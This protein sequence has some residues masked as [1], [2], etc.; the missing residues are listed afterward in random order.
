MVLIKTC[1]AIAVAATSCFVA[2]EDLAAASPATAPSVTYIAYGMFANPPISGSDVFELAG[3]PFSINVVA[4][5]AAVPAQNGKQ[6][7]QYDDLKLTGTVYS[8]LEPSPVAITSGAA[9]VT[10][11]TGNPSLDFFLLAAPVRVIGITLTI[12]AEISMPLGTMASAHVHPFTAPVTLTPTT[13]NVTYSDG[14]AST[15]LGINGTLTTSVSDSQ[16]SVAHAG[17]GLEAA[18]AQAITAHADGTQ[19][20]RSLGAAPI[21]LGSPADVVVLQFYASGVSG[22]AEVRAQIAG[23]PAPVLYAGPAGHFPGLE[24]VS[25]Q[26]PRSLAGRGDADVTL[27]VDSQASNPV[28]I[29]IQ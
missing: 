23:E 7:A 21:D 24:Q 14:T 5:E 11:A 3:Q 16:A 13:A 17:V 9:A 8:G 27:T 18:G 12:S 19:S 1:V 26:V 15:T 4:S 22:A 20:V 2:A 25:V 10:L 28:S 6:W 29:H